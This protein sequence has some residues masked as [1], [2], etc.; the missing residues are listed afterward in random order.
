MIQA[1]GRFL[2]QGGNLTSQSPDSWGWMGRAPIPTRNLRSYSPT[3]LG[4]YGNQHF[5]KNGFSTISVYTP[6]IQNLGPQ[7]W[8]VELQLLKVVKQE[9]AS[10]ELLHN[11]K[12]EQPY[13]FLQREKSAK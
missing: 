10:R 13:R 9:F 2:V 8:G 11:G 12:N 5:N 6:R 4:R 3:S 1:D 7:S